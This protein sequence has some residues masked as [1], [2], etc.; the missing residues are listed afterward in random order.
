MKFISARDAKTHL[1]ATL[2]DCQESRVVITRHGKPVAM[3]LGCEGYDL[4]DLWWATN[5]RFWKDI[6]Q[7]RRQPERTYDLAEVRSRLTSKAAER[8]APHG[9]KR[10]K[11]P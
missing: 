11:R 3:L 9:G 1:A 7:S 10:K 8:R 6:E 5:E 4:E 2:R